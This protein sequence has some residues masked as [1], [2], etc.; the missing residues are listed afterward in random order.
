MKI[1]AASLIFVAIIV[2]L[3]IVQSSLASH[4]DQDIVEYFHSGK[5]IE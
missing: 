3:D 5:H 4:L 1:G 2:G